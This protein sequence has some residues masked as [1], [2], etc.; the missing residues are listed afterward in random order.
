M[1]A[2]PR[3]Q[4]PILVAIFQSRLRWLVLISL[5]LLLPLHKS[6]LQLAHDDQELLKAQFPLFRI[7]IFQQVARLIRISTQALQNGLQVLCVHKSGFLVIEHVKNALEVFDL[8]LGIRL[9]NVVVYS[10]SPGQECVLTI[11]F[12]R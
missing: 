7:Q 2:R 6:V 5:S 3:Q 4:R 9:E 1:H 11:A 8:L 12:S 10:K